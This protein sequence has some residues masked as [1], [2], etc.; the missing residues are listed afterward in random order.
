MAIADGK[1]LIGWGAVRE[2]PWHFAG[3]YASQDEAQGKADEMGDGFIVRYGQRQEIDD[4]FTSSEGVVPSAIAGSIF[5]S[6]P[7]AENAR[8]RRAAVAT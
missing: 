5:E 6:F 8:D 7:V 2:A 3:L 1:T 4:T